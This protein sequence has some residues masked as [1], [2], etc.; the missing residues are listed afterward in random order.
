MSHQQRSVL[1]RSLE[2]K[3]AVEVKE[4][5]ASYPEAEI[6]LWCED[7]HRLGLKPILQRI[8]VPEGETPIANVNW[9]FKWLW[10]YAFVH[11]Q[12]GE[13]YYWILPYLNSQ[14]FNQVLDRFAHQFGL[15][16][17]KRILL[18]I[19]RAGWHI[20]KNLKIPEGLHLIFLP[21]YSPELQPAERLWTLVDEPIANRAFDTLDELEDV[22]F[23]RCQ[24]LLQQQNLIRGLTG[25]Y[26]W[27]QIGV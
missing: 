23:A 2:K 11:P 12:S 6:Q 16:A 24:S 26:W 19:D 27:I 5:Q 25:F 22:L 20:S 21:S 18:A 1:S 15:G 10:L 4:L 7:E 8:Y 14:L 9:R 13:S 3:L 17:N